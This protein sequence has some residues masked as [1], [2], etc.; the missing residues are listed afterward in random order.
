MTSIKV[1]IERKPPI[2]QKK[3]PSGFDRPKSDSDNEEKRDSYKKDNS[4][5]KN[6]LNDPM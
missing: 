1:N 3:K 2:Y 5:K 4:G 6:E